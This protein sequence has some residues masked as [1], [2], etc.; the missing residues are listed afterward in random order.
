MKNFFKKYRKIIIV[1]ISLIVVIIIGINLFN[2]FMNE[3]SLT[4]E[5]RTWIDDNVGNVVNINVVNDANVMASFG[6][7][8][9][10]DFLNDFEETY[11]ELEIN[12]ITS[13]YENAIGGLSF[14]Y[15]T[16]VSEDDIIFYEDNYVLLSKAEIQY[17]TYVELSGKTIGIV[18]S[19]EDIIQ[20]GLAD[21]SIIYESFN[22]RAELLVA[23]EGDMEYIIVPLNLYLDEIL[24]NNYNVALQL[25]DIIGYYVMQPDDSIISSIMEKYYNG[26]WHENIYDSFKN[27]EFNIFA[28]S[29]NISEAEVDKLRSVVHSYGFISNAPYD[30][31]ASGEFGGISA[32]LLKEFSDFSDIDFSFEKYSSYDELMSAIDNKSV[33]LYFNYYNKKTDYTNTINGLDLNYNIVAT[34]EN[35]IVINS[36]NALSGKEVYVLK[37]SKLYDVLTAVDNVSIKT[38]ETEKELLK[39]NDEDVLII[40]DSN[41]FNY[42]KSLGLNNY[43]SRFTSETE[44]ELTYATKNNDVMY[45]LLNNYLKVNNGDKVVNRGIYNYN[46]TIK[47][48]NILST[49]ARYV[50]VLVILGV[51]V[52]Y[53][54]IKKSKKIKI[55]KKIKKDDKMKFIDQLTSLKNRNYL[56]ECL[57]SWNNNTIYPQSLIVVDL[58]DIQ[59]LNDIHGYNEGDRQIKMFANALIKTQL[60]NSE[61]MR[62]DGNE[63][64]VYLIG[65]N[66]KQITNYIH[67]LN[68]EVEKLPFDNGAKFGYSMILDNLKTIED[69]LNEASNDM[70]AKKKNE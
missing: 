59:K 5:E 3:N 4:V 30:V 54:L 42:Y 33:E 16:N 64:V 36:I 39:L 44:V 32:V 17:E 47:T 1:V 29:L 35:D 34:K 61:I 6:E 49:L 21:D 19:D 48:G 12:P 57:E 45:L 26:N 50:I 24:M 25:S 67:K 58:N 60:D 18:S 38:Y 2:I 11:T 43:S 46:E 40:I 70:K 68:K 27:S 41:A 15:K 69:C 31:I 13:S 14:I 51:I 28:S 55:A 37:N 10:Y 65:Y 8:V 52:T 56:N 9:F 66:Q 7:G 20:N 23:F 62:T 63:F 22:S 53:I